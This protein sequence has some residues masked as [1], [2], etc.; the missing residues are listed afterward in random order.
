MSLNFISVDQPIRIEFTSFTARESHIKAI[1]IEVFHQEQ[2]IDPAL[3]FDGLDE[4]AIQVVAYIG[5]QPVGTTRIRQLAAATKIE[6]VAVLSPYRKQGVGTAMMLEILT[7][8]SDRSS[9]DIILSAQCTSESFYRKLGFMP[10]GEVFREAGI[11]HIHMRY[12]PRK[13]R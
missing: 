4:E 9:T 12:R 6:R 3:D 8:L 7:Y 11:E 1:R 2:K 5:D 10:H 13:G